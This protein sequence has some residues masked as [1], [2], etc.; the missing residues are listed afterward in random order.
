MEILQKPIANYLGR[1]EFGIG[2]IDASDVTKEEFTEQLENIKD[3]HLEFVSDLRLVHGSCMDG[4]SD[5]MT[6]AGNRVQGTRPK[7]IGGP[8]LFAWY[9]A[10]IGQFEILEGI[11]NPID[12]FAAV[13][14]KLVQAG[15]F[16]GMHR[17]C[18]AA[19]GVVPVLE[20]YATNFSKIH[21]LVGAE[22]RAV[23]ELKDGKY[24]KEILE[25]AEQAYKTA[26]TAG[27]SFSEEEMLKVVL[28]L[29]D[30]EAVTHLEVDLEHETHGHQEDGLIFMRIRN[31]M[32][33]KASVNE[34][35]GRMF[36]YNN[37]LYARGIIE[38]LARNQDE[39]AKG[40]IIA[41]QLPIAG[42]ATLGRQQHIA[43]LTGQL[44]AA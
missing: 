9:A 18:G 43:E 39:L 1:V 6:E 2:N 3:N 37:S 16:L 14:Q 11:E 22:A 4:R 15:I 44:L 10:S 36:F 24:M 5:V 32:I 40:V 12:Q 38:V 29:G 26:T 23:S 17:A 20:N 30:P 34:E 28:A 8:S 27:D 31:A 33:S 42:V 41:D 35:T 25:G 13:N 21:Q 7:I 19:R